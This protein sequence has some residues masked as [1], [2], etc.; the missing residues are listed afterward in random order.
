[1]GERE[2]R[3]TP[4]PCAEL[5]CG[6]WGWG[7]A[8]ALLPTGMHLADGLLC[9]QF[10]QHGLAHGNFANLPLCFIPTDRRLSPDEP[11][12]G[13]ESQLYSDR[14][15]FS[16]QKMLWRGR[17]HLILTSVLIFSLANG[18]RL[19]CNMIFLLKDRICYL[20][21]VGIHGRAVRKGNI[22]RC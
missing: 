3:G 10:H 17:K 4:V 16:P 14:V 19:Q 11:S 21:I 8:G 20:V 7:H 5:L 2:S 6:S 1:M 18:L 9:T 12:S 13:S 22:F 15:F